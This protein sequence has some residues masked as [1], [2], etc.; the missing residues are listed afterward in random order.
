V[1]IINRYVLKEHIGPFIFALSAITSLMLLQYIARKFGDLVGKGLSWQVIVE[2]LVLSVPFT[3]AM[4]FPMAVLVA[5]LY[6]F[7]RFGAE[8]EITALKASGISARSLLTPVLF[9]AA[10]LSLFMIGFNDQILPRSNHRL[11]T[12]QYDIFQTKPTFILR[13]GVINAVKEGMLYLRASRID[14]GSSTMYDVAIDDL[15]DHQRRRTIIADSGHLELAPNQRDLTLT[16]Y[17]GVIISLPTDRQ[18]QLSRLYFRA[19]R[20]RVSD[21]FRE[22]RP[23]EAREQDKG[24][25]EM[26][27]CEMQRRLV[28]SG[29]NLQRKQQDF[30]HAQWAERRARGITEPA[31]PIQVLRNP[32]G[33]GHYYCEATTA[34]AAWVL[35]TWGRIGPREASAQ[36]ALS[37]PP[38]LA[39]PPD[40]TT[41]PVSPA[42]ADA[43]GQLRMTEAEYKTAERQRNRW[44]IEI[45]KKF[46][47]A[48]ACLVLALVGAPIALRFPRGG[49]GL[50]IG[51]SFSIFAIYYVCLIGGESLANR[52]VV[53]PWLS[54][55]IANVV[56]LIVGLVLYARMSSGAGNTRG[57][58]AGEMFAVMRMWFARRIRPL[59]V[60]LDRRR[61]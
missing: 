21:V 49:I 6:A 11:A 19:D 5:V 25:R 30:A 52:A 39:T 45:H 1:K 60:G 26:G 47:L 61:A 55:W 17:D 2:F 18:G 40:S 13:E 34:A 8:N 35:K 51:V 22:F 59:G 7:S 9:A 58:D 37:T 12:L 43:L 56:F 42:H 53:E 16:L 10:G 38:P 20:M 32:L 41:V 27:I 28:S 15:S 4:T 54:M 14:Q 31:P 3:M 44:L 23:S 48:T 46:S 57:G 50:V 33:L 36:S 24:D 29:R